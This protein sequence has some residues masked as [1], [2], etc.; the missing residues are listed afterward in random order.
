MLITL[1]GLDG[2]GKSTQ[3]KLI[4]EWL[5]AK[6]F[7]STV[8]DKWDIFDLHAHP[9]CRFISQDLDLL[10]DCI[11]EMHGESRALF[12]IWTIATTLKTIKETKDHIYISDGYWFKHLAAETLYGNN[13]G[14]L[15]SLVSELPKADIVIYFSVDV[16]GTAKRKSVY[17][18]YEC[19]R[20][21]VNESSFRAH[22]TKLKDLLDSWS[23]EFNW[24]IID[25]NQSPDV[26]FASLQKIISP[27]VQRTYE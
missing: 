14:W 24:R 23:K 10:R 8:L 18:P 22:Q 15:F 5:K 27:A 25:A 13:K 4:E 7:N 19:G 17:T 12:L 2:A 20:N 1:V 21:A 11:S 6:D 16:D 9:E 26:V 3:C